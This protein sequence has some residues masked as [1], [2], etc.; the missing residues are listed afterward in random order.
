MKTVLSALTAALTISLRET[1]NE[2]TKT[3]IIH[4]L[5]TTRHIGF[6]IE[7]RTRTQLWTAYADRADRILAIID[8]GLEGTDSSTHV[9]V[10]PA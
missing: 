10:E 9:S 8:D 6:R 5:G 2:A 3:A 4:A 1:D 7:F